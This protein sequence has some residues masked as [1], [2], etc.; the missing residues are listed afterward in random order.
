VHLS[1]LF[2]SFLIYPLSV[3]R[4]IQRENGVEDRIPLSISIGL[5]DVKEASSS[6]A[7]QYKFFSKT[8]IMEQ[9][10]EG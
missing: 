6:T 1:A 8:A 2:A 5:T 10:S 4:Q 3:I 7:K 9:K